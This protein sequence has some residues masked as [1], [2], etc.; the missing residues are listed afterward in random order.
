[1]QIRLRPASRRETVKKR[2]I[3][4]SALITFIFISIISITVITG[5]GDVSGGGDP[6]DT[7]TDTATPTDS[8][9][10]TGT[11]TD[12]PTA[13]DSP[14]DTATDTA[15]P[16]D[17]ATPTDSPTDT[18]TDTPT[19][20][21]SST[22]TATD[23]PTPTDSSTN[24]ATD[25]ATP[26][27]S[28]T[29]TATDT[30]TPTDSSTNTPTDTA[31]PTDTA[32]NTPTP[33]DSSTNTATDTP[34]PTDSPTDTA[35]DTPTP[36]DTATDTPTSTDSPTNTAT[37]TPTPTPS[38]TPITYTVTYDG[39]G[40]TGGSVPV[41]STLYITGNTVTV[42]ANTGGLVKTGYSFTGWCV[43][44]IGTGTSY[45]A[46]NTFLMG[47][48]NVT[49]Y[50]K[51]TALPTYTVTYVP[52]NAMGGS[53]PVDST[54][55]IVGS[56]VTVLG[57]TG[58]LYRTG[59]SFVGWDDLDAGSF[60]YPGNQFVIDGNIT[61]TAKWSLNPTYTV[62]YNGN[63]NTSGTV[64]VD[65][66]SYETGAQVTVLANTGN[67]AKTGYNFTGWNTAS[68]GSG[69][70]YSAGNHFNMGSANVILYAKWTVQTTFT[71]T[72]NDNG[73]DSGSV[74]VD[75]STYLEND[76][77]TVL[78]NS[79]GLVKADYAFA[80]W[81][82]A[83]DGSGTS[84]DP[85]QTFN[86]GT[87]N[88]LLYAKW[89]PDS[90]DSWVSYDVNGL[91]HADYDAVACSD[92]GQYIYTVIRGGSGI[93]GGIYRSTDSGANWSQEYTTGRQFRCV[94][95]SASGQYV[96]AGVATGNIYVSTNYGDSF[97]ARASYLAWRG[98]AMDS[99]GQYMVAN[100]GAGSG[101]I[102][103]STNYGTNWSLLT[104]SPTANYRGIA[105]SADG[106]VLAAIVDDGGI[107]VSTDSGAT[108]TQT[109]AMVAAWRGISISDDGTKMSAAIQA[110]TYPNSGIWVSTDSGSTWSQ[111]DSLS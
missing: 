36:T 86:M 98:V 78:G 62:T 11:P 83:S 40:N 10:D 20:T 67:L 7:P 24:T 9:T 91:P 46:G 51:W 95:T 13:T 30:P 100:I 42:L 38:P 5:C 31:S 45:V 94:A 68:D 41:D 47:S 34:T 35:T 110:G 32:T 8:P 33:T 19:P 37:D 14:T 49:L 22:D 18:A 39:N 28:P 61:L 87:S 65:S 16:I 85:N 23:T 82:T 102:Y 50:A 108:W 12:S 15:T 109:L 84:Y 71:V 88:V 4:L 99:T 70:S 104:N 64:P 92:D 74:P 72:Y 52:N 111:T 44:A 55:Y 2:C 48:A 43:N 26:T 97:T 79:G 27:D 105:S 73:A 69:T 77:V 103:R 101:R 58:G 66:T 56:S 25:T 1:M 76:E 63:G 93:Y 80:G 96:A 89:A 6:L 21:D 75:G 3:P 57:N 81:N 53:V 90:S 17:T 60:Y 59:Y 54:N 106:T 107:Y 29:D